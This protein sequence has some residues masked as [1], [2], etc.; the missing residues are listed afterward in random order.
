MDDGKKVILLEFNELCPQLL[1]RFMQA[2]ELPNF[3]RLYAS[4]DVYVTD[5]KCDVEYL[6][7]WIQWVTLHT[8][9]PFEKHQVFR[10]G[11]AQNLKYDSIWDVLARHNKTSWLC[12]SMNTKWDTLDKKITALPDPWSID[13]VA[14]PEALQPFYR[15]VRANVQ[16]HSNDNFKLSALDYL[17]FFW[18][19]IRH[20]LSIKTSKKLVTMLWKQLTK[21]EDRW[22]KATVLDWLQFDVFKYIYQRE[23]PHFATFFSNS[24]AHFQ[25]K[26]W[27]YMEPEKFPLKPTAAEIK[28][29]GDAVLFAYKN[30]DEIIGEMLKLTDQNTVVILSSALSQQPYTLK[31]SEGG[32]RFY[33]PHDMQAIPSIF[34]LTGVK[35][36]SP[37]MSHQFHLLCDNEDIARENFE[38]LQRMTYSG[39]PLFSLRLEGHDV[40]GGCR[41]YTQVPEQAVFE[42]DGKTLSFHKVF[43]LADS[44]KSGMHH[45]HGVF[46]LSQQGRSHQKVA[47]PIPLE[48]TMPRILNEFSL[49]PES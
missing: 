30:H 6:E 34:G 18:F 8:G 21:A 41:I 3:S 32:K 36:V 14:S 11:Q 23:K 37:V 1:E 40:F 46:W 19:M 35:A 31:D 39:G 42:Y 33:R 2:G 13:V 7:P 44:L 26:Y 12:G 29:Y 16:E 15:F 28:K 4:A 47:E 38:R 22:K 43:Y 20:G 17:S 49:Q 25:H 48:Q 9:L 10:L 24:T 5:A 27:R 45:P